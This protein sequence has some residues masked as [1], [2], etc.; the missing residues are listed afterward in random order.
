MLT[1]R[2][3]AHGN[4]QDPSDGLNSGSEEEGAS[5]H[6]LA[7]ESFSARRAARSDEGPVHL[8]AH[9]PT[10]GQSSRSSIRYASAYPVHRETGIPHGSAHR[11]AEWTLSSLCAPQ[12]H[13]A[14]MK[15]K[16]RPKREGTSRASSHQPPI[17]SGFRAA[18]P[19]IG[20][21]V[22]SSN[23]NSCAGRKSKSGRED[24]QVSPHTRR[25]S[26]T[27]SQPPT[28]FDVRL[29]TPPIEEFPPPPN[30]NSRR[31]RRRSGRDARSLRVNSNLND[32]KSSS[33]LEDADADPLVSTNYG[34]FL[35][36][37]PTSL[38]SWDAEPN[39]PSWTYLRHMPK[40]ESTGATSWHLPARSDEHIPTQRDDWSS[41]SHPDVDGQSGTF[42]I[43]S[44]R[45]GVPECVLRRP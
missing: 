31:A 44:P 17:I 25:T 32:I 21:F 20:G 39:A 30:P 22:P 18:T 19:L 42:V 3:T 2:P 9:T 4:H 14:H 37:S 12:P 27:S 5:S 15:R 10:H 34:T 6:F 29:P 7:P 40:D 16:H 33:N 13:P 11:S 24:H 45:D 41:R 38:P 26:R 35:R 36:R 1:T 43:Y 23:A 8:P 28:F